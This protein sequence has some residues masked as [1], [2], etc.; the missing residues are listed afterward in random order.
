[1][2]NEDGKDRPAPSLPEGAAPITKSP[3]RRAKLHRE[4]FARIRIR[5]DR[6]ARLWVSNLAAHDVV[7]WS[8]KE[9]RWVALL[10]VPELR[11]ALER[12]EAELPKDGKRVPSI[13]PTTVGRP[14]E[15]LP[16]AP[17]L[18]LMDPVAAGLG[19]LRLRSIA[20]SQGAGLVAP[21]RVSYPPMLPPRAVGEWTAQRRQRTQSRQRDLR[22]TP[23][24]WH[25]R[26][27]ERIAWVAAGV[28]GMFV[29]SS[30]GSTTENGA[31]LEP[32][33]LLLTADYLDPIAQRSN[34]TGNAATLAELLIGSPQQCQSRPAPCPSATNTP[35][36]EPQVEER[37]RETASPALRRPM[38]ESPPRLRA[39]PAQRA[40][41]EAPTSDAQVPP[42]QV[43]LDLN[44]PAIR[45]AL[46]NAAALARACPGENVSGKTVVTFEPN[47][48]VRSVDI[49]LLIGERPDRNCIVRAFKALRVPPFTGRAVAVKKDF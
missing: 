1:M 36:L 9:K 22:A 43:P 48:T 5:E 37:G 7:V 25:W 4:W 26:A 42:D 40:T 38:T 15:S 34:D 23:Q 20:Q 21:G 41:P 19:E 2:P 33:A 39:L 14:P 49:P 12:A 27:L 8:K 45:A 24:P 16:P 18:A 17:P 35:A 30:A 6:L 47:G 46:F 11:S 3:Q 32:A 13:A 29:V 44:F 28:V 31:R 10:A